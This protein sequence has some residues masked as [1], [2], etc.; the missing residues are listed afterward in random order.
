MSRKKSQNIYSPV[1]FYESSFLNDL[2]KLFIDNRSFKYYQDTS[3]SE[4][5]AQC[6][7]ETL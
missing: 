7:Q 1:L 3:F 2:F 6:W 5:R 4:E